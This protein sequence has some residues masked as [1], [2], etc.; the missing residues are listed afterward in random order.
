MEECNICFNE[1]K[2]FIFHLVHKWCMKCN[3]NPKF[4]RKCPFLK[5]SSSFISKITKKSWRKEQQEELKKL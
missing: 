4:P 5:N 2:I 3:L 1:R